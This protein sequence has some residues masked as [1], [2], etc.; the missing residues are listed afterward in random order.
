MSVEAEV[1]AQRLNN[2]GRVEVVGQRRAARAAAALEILSDTELV[3]RSVWRSRWIEV[4]TIQVERPGAALAELAGAMDPP[5]TKN[6]FSGILNRA[7]KYAE[8]LARTR[9]PRGGS[10]KSAVGQVVREVH[11]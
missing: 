3:S 8:E 2:A 10:T 1:Q 9:S 7:C 11:S 6:T 5:V 4:L